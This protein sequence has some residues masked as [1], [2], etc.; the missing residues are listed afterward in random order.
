MLF[1]VL[2]VAAFAVIL[3]GAFSLMRQGFV[4]PAPAA[5]RTRR[6]PEAPEPGEALLYV[7]LN[8]ERLEALYQK[9]S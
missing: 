6:H 7:D 3:C 1:S 9:A 4:T 5:R 8:R 2:Y